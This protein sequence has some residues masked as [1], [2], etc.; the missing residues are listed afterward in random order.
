MSE[1]I[2]LERKTLTIKR[3]VDHAEL[4]ERL[5]K[6]LATSGLGA[7]RG[8]EERIVRGEILLNALVPEIGA[9]VKVGDRIT[10]DGK[11]FVV[12]LQEGDFG[13]VLLYNKPDG[14]VTT[15]HDPEGRRTVFESLPRIRGARWIAVGRLDINTQGLLVF[16]TNGDLAQK[17]THPTNEFEREYLCRVHGE[18][19]EA[20]VAKLLAGVELSDGPANFAECE[21]M[22]S[23]GGSNEWWR[24]VI[25]EGRNREVRRVWEAVELQV[26]RL[27][28]SRFGPFALP[29]GLHRSEVAELDAADVVQICTELGIGQNPAQLVAE[30]ESASKLRRNREVTPGAN[31]KRFVAVDAKRAEAFWTGER[32]YGG[33]N[34]KKGRVSSEFDMGQERPRVPGRKKF[35]GKGDRRGVPMSFPSGNAPGTERKPRPPGTGRPLRGPRPPGSAPRDPNQVRAPGASQPRSFAPRPPRVPGERPP[36]G[37]PRSPGLG[38]DPNTTRFPSSGADAQP[39]SFGRGAPRVRKAFTGPMDNPMPSQDHFADGEEPNGNVALP[40]NADG[41]VMPSSPRAPRPTRDGQPGRPPQ[42]G[43][44]RGREP[45]RGRRGPPRAPGTAPRDPNSTLPRDPNSEGQAPGPR[46]PGRNPPRSGPGRGPARPPSAPG[47]AASAEA[48]APSVN[49]RRRRRRGKPGGGAGAP[50]SSPAGGAPLGQG[51]NGEASSE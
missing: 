49:K 38:N 25:K 5:Q 30:D 42:E 17:L 7:R 48:G 33:E 50:A 16:T 36:R 24:V 15:R 1:D 41:N 3:S 26:S 31:K 39:P 22:D 35:A 29:K 21:P 40:F 4:R 44:R 37:T 51:G 47:D 28:R 10:L 46:G 8:L 12:K 27:K 32:G 9:Q 20:T 18:V 34:A 6:V 43:P 13:R 2:N 11:T 23:A 14:E 19:T 45:G